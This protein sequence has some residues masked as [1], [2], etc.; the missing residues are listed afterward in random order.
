MFCATLGRTRAFAH[1][2]RTLRMSPRAIEVAFQD[3]QLVD[4]FPEALALPQGV[5]GIDALWTGPNGQ[6]YLFRG[7]QYWT[8]DTNTLALIEPARPLAALCAD[9][10]DLPAVDAVYTVPSGVHWLLAAGRAWRWAA[11]SESWVETAR[12]WGR[13]QSRFDDPA[14]ID[15]ALLDQEGR[16]HL[17]S[18]DQYVRY[19]SWPQEFVDEGYPRRI[20]AQWS[21]ELD[22][23]PLPPGWDA[24]IDAAV[25]RQDEV[26]WLFKGN[27]YVASTEP[28][29][30][31]SIVEVWGRVRNNLASA[32]RV[33]AVL[34]MEGRCSVV[35]GDQVSVFSNSLES[36]GLTA[37][38]GY[39]RTLAAVFQGLPEA[40]T[41]GIDAGLTD[42]NG[43]LHLFRDQQCAIRQD[44]K[45]EVLPTR[46]RWGR[47]RNTLQ[48]TGRV[49][50]ALT[51]LDGKVYLF[52]GDQYVRYNG[53]DLSR[54]DEGYPRTISRDWGGLTRVDAAFVLDGK[55]YVF[56]SGPNTD[57]YV[58]YSTRD[59][60]KVD[61]GFP[62]PIDDN[63]WNLPEALMLR[64]HAPDAVFVAPDGRIHLF[65]G[66]QT[67][68]FDHNHRWWS[69]PV[70]IR[71]AWS[72]LPFAR[73]S[74]AFTARDGRSY[75]FST[76]EEP[77]FVRYTDPTFQRVDDRF[78]KPVK[79]NW[80]KVV[81]HLERT[82][83][84]DAAVMLVS[85][86]TETATDGTLS[87]RKQR[88][89]YL[90]S[91][92]Q[93]YR[94]TSD[95]QP[96]V[97]EGYP[98]RIQHNLRREPHFAHF[99]APAERGVDGVWA[100]T[101]NVFVFISDRIHVASV[102]HLR[103]LDGLGVDAPRAADVEEGR[104]TVFSKDG[105]RHIRPP[106]AHSRA[107]EP[108]LPRILRTVPPPFQGKLSAI[109]RGLDKNVYLFSDD[110]CYDWSLERHYPT[111]AAWGHVRNRIAEDE[112]V[113]SALM[114][115]D[116]TFYLF[117]GD[118]FVSYTP[119]PEAP[120]QLP[121]VADTTPSS[122]AA[123]WGGLNNVRHAFVHQ[124]VTYVLEAP[125]EDGTFRYVR[126]FGTDYSR[127]N[128]PTPL[129]GDFS[130][131]Q[132][133]DDYVTRGFDRVDAVLAEGDDLILIRD[134]Q[135]L[136]YEAATDTWTFPRPLSL[137]W[138]GLP[139]RHPDFETMRAV[140]RGPDAKTYFFADGAWLAHDG[141]RP[142]ALATISSRWALLRNRI[143]RS[144]RIDAT[145]VHGEQTFLFSG[146]EY[147]RYT[148][149]N[150]QYVDAGYPRPIAGFLRLEAPFQ[151]LPAAIETAFERLEPEDVWLAAVFCT[152][153]V[154][155]LSV[156][157]RSY[158]LSAQLS[159]SY[160]L[161]QIT[162]VRNE[163]VRRARVDAAFARQDGAL[164][165]LSGDQ[166]VRYSGPDLDEVDDGYPRAIG[167]S[168]LR[169]LADEPPT[170]PLGF[171]YDLDAA[172][173]DKNGVLVLFKGTHFVRCEPNARGGELVPQEIK[174][175]WG[176]VSNPFLPSPG[177]PRPHIDAAFVASDHALY[178]FQDSQYVRYANPD[179]EFVDE[180]YPR[181]MRDRWGDLPPAFEAGID[182]GFVFG[183]R[184]YLCREKHYV[185][186]SD[187]SYRLMDPIYPQLFTS[188]WRAANAFLLR[189]LRT[190]Q[191]YVA[192]DQ[193]HPT[194]DASLTDFLLGSPRDKVDPYVLLATL[195]A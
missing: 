108:A 44:G 188:R 134:T 43:T 169:E 136:H 95:A 178:V 116:G 29:V 154:V 113:D 30:E 36:E 174:G 121:D 130:F 103:Q 48:D 180:G 129:S 100:D 82:G 42:E 181:A 138:P 96:F 28:S 165:L 26:T 126:Y 54:I 66:D 37:D 52:S 179:A 34:D 159:R 128:E 79:E 14:S 195:F 86:V 57:S 1:F 55:T 167:E 58:C 190:I 21:Q 186:Y 145:F 143:T 16:I 155:C 163:L 98:L 47:V 193:S 71:E 24:G 102:A 168:L 92:D 74:A 177:N 19:S 61:E 12:T 49:D 150:Y 189:D 148:G 104:L 147:V 77:A 18:E 123:R 171:Q 122:V 27:R 8:F 68:S 131:W 192:L 97:D 75:L 119:T 13:V 110:Q 140:V 70:P 146:D 62:K 89:R 182:G 35:V 46:E 2:A 45:W 20:A 184:T 22:F 166:Y 183:G 112:R 191:R 135:F 133:P 132:I 142:S 59:Y 125:E 106:E 78:P 41:Q 105:W 124:G 173:Y 120:A 107:A 101:G 185:R 164:L 72:S 137:R 64:F 151:Q 115:R 127:P 141:E 94:Y 153:G 56:G 4:K 3:Q 139:R 156:A 23:G 160:P 7:P 73:V 83:R 15:G 149:S 65:R 76:E 31:R 53:A 32:S 10:K 117:R 93:F 5:D 161:Q 38:E 84:V 80:G 6:L 194:E 172:L 81:S 158:A 69:E 170:L 118:Q 40:F 176:R 17:F 175:V 9:F 63:W 51:G 50:A 144:N 11:D 67:I 39:P 87:A 99:D 162:R 109:L 33:D 60:T 187:P 91:G 152:G 114:G 25:G 90:F 157:G 88:Y 111:G 85:T